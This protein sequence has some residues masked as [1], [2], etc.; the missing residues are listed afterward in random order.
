M[1]AIHI[2]VIGADG[3]GKSS[4]I[5]RALRMSRIPTSNVSTVRIEVEA[6]IYAVTLIELDIEYFD[7]APGQQI[8]WPKQING[9]IISRVDCAMVLYDVMNKETIRDLPPVISALSASS[10][11]TMLVA[12]KCDNPEHLRQ[13]D[14]MGMDKAF[15]SCLDNVKTSA[16]VPGSTRD[17]LQAMLKAVIANRRGKDDPICFFCI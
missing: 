5:Q 14:T 16:N 1:E 7:V 13:V 3:T 12:T 6:T 10:L 8:L 2:A 17:C 11:P 15:P 4:F 9:H